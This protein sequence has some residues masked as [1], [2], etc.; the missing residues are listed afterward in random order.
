MAPRL[1]KGMSLTATVYGHLV[2]LPEG[3]E[4]T[5]PVVELLDTYRDEDGELVQTLVTYSLRD[6]LF[7]FSVSSLTEWKDF[8]EQELYQVNESII[9]YCD[10]TLLH[11][12]LRE[13]EKD[14]DQYRAWLTAT[15]M[16]VKAGGT[17]LIYI[18]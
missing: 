4:D 1:L 9:D 18:S 2:A 12:D 16:V 6:P 17:A 8:T 13:A 5:G 15:E 3:H 11:Q 7:S 10:C 14:T